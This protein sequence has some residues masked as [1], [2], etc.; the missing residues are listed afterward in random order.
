MGGVGRGNRGGEGLGERGKG[1][2]E[3]GG[4][5][6]GGRHEIYRR[7]TM[8]MFDGREYRMQDERGGE[9]GEG[10]GVFHIRCSILGREARED[11]D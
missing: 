5:E 6:N 9:G 11:I 1:Q 2:R 4:R 8:N 7:R 10:G 3:K